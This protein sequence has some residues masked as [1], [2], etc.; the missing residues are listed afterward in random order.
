MNPGF[1]L[2]MNGKVAVITLNRPEKKNAL[3]PAFWQAFPEAIEDLSSSGSARVIVLNARGTDFCS[4][5]D[6]SVFAGNE[7]LNTGTAYQREQLYRLILKIQRAITVLERSRIPVIASIHGKCLGAG[8][9]IVAACDLRYATREALFR[10]EETNIGIMADLGSLQRLPGLMPEAIVKE[11]AYTGCS[12]GAE[13]A[14]Q[15][16]FLNQLFEDTDSLEK[17]V[18]ETAESIA[19]KPPLVVS[20]SKQSINYAR[21]HSIEESLDN[22]ALRQSQ[23]FDPSEIALFMKCRSKNEAHPTDLGPEYKEL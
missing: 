15:I 2:E 14:F 9:D 4:G 1:E 23:L 19:A 18:L 7:K 8:L 20:G 12:L 21:E 5:M 10:I 3:S 22:A 16:G 11:M 6:L 13:R 17:S